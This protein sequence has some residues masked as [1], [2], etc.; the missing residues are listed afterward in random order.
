MAPTLFTVRSSLTGQTRPVLP[1]PHSSL[2]PPSPRS[3]PAAPQPCSLRTRGPPR[4]CLEC[5]PVRWTRSVPRALPHLFAWPTLPVHSLRWQLDIVSPK[6]PPG[7]LC[8]LTC[9]VLGQNDC[10]C[11]RLPQAREVRVGRFCSWLYITGHSV[12][13]CVTNEQNNSESL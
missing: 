1:S 4:G 6:K 13:T 11:S 3:P 10:L 2:C 8:P 9:Y 7:S 12:V 5:L